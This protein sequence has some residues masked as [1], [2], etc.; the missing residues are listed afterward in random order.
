MVT[1]VATG[2]QNQE[3][4]RQLQQTNVDLAKTTFQI[5]TGFKDDS[6][7]G[8][9]TDANALLDIYDLQSNT[10][11]YME[12]ISTAKSRLQST[13]SALQGMNDLLSEAASL[14]TLGR[15]EN[16]AETR[17]ALAPKAESITNTFYNIFN[18]KFDGRYIFSGQNGA[19]A[20]TNATAT[21]T[22]FPGS[23]V[24]TTYYI[25]D[26][27]KPAIISGPGQTTQYGVTGD[28]TAIANIKAGLE[29]LWYGLENN[30]ETDIDQAIAALTDAQ[31][32]LS[33]LLGD[34]GGQLSS[35]TQLETRH[36][37]QKV[38]LQEQADDLDKVDIAE[39]MTTLTQQEATLQASML[40]ITSV[41]QLSLL[42]FLR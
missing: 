29:A 11:M 34:V 25:G 5:T 22:A 39:A 13:E 16:S 42:D 30:S 20:P 6:L 40:V 3:S 4:L 24:P 7:S 37:N 12:N 28:E 14:W 8:F 38:F 9:A 26:S 33:S 41:N 27:A 21:S 36:E 17:A 10:D 32:E 15:T 19:E 31:E 23:P 1:R 18:T 2:Y 35:F